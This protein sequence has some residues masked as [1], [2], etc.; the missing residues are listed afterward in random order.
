MAEFIIIREDL[1]LDP[2]TII[3]DGL[4]IGR[5]QECELLLNHP[6]V[7]RAQAGIKRLNDDYYLFSLRQTNPVKLNGKLIETN[8]ALAP[9]DVVEVGPFQLEFDRADGAL[10]I[11]V[12][13]QMGMVVEATDLSSPNIGTA[14]LLSQDDIEAKKP[15]K[16]R[17]APLPGDKALDI[18]WDKRIREAGKMIRPSPLFPKSNRRSGKTQFNW[19]PTTDLASRWPIS[20][21]IWGAIAVG[22]VSVSAAYWYASAYAPAPVANAHSKSKLDL[23]PPIA[24]RANSNSCTS[25]H[26]LS[27]TMESNCVACHTAEGFVATVI[28][29]H[30]AAGIGCISCHAEHRGADFKAGEAALTGCTGCHNDANSKT[31]NGR[32]VGTPHAGTLGYPVVKG[33]WKWMGLSDE[34]WA[35]KKLPVER[36]AEDSDEQWRSKQFHALHVQRL[37]VVPGLGGNAE[38]ELSCSSCHQKF[39]PI[40]RETPRKT[41]GAC[42]YGSIDPQSNRVLIAKDQPNCISCH[43]QHVKSKRHWSPGLLVSR[44]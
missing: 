14:K 31:F 16:A 18:F 38:G 22:L 6:S 13:L 23:A 15:A 34:D 25:C 36:L 10:V 41:C 11:R 39:N 27:G 43:V 29:P 2:I 4:L 12:S 24:A 26:S 21:F 8:E 9:G 19:A 5:L 1:V 3:S 7:S 28:E 30:A 33:S 32:K 17:A 42:H 35:L 20:I 37:R 40:D 44:N